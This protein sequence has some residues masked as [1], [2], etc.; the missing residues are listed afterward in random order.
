MNRFFR[1]RFVTVSL[2]TGVAIL[3]QA[4]AGSPP[5]SPT[6][7]ANSATL[8]V[9]DP[10]PAFTLP[11]A[12]GGDASLSDFDG[13][14]VLLYFSMTSGWGPCLKQIVDL[15][16]DPSFQNSQVV[17]VSIGT[18]PLPDLAAAASE[19][20][21][22][23]PLLS[24]GDGNVS[25]AFGVLRWATPSGE[26]G[27][28]FVLVGQD[29]NVKWIRDYGARQNGGRMYANNPSLP[30]PITAMISFCCN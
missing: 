8:A 24:D 15:Q 19:W 2:V 26:P 9:G 28:T 5:P 21:V 16:S 7:A 13:K 12:L 3:L 18:D 4:C 30:A 20:N 22:T 25:Q 10:A 27:H 11:A 17:L 23:T 14:N 29:G 1:I 6:T